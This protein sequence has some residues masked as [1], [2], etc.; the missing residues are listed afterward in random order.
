MTAAAAYI[1][2]LM[3]FQEKRTA[4]RRRVLKGGFVS[5]NGRHSD[6]PCTVRDIS[7][8]GARLKVKDGVNIP[9]RFELLIELDGLEAQCEVVRREINEVGVRFLSA[10]RQGVPM[11]VQILSQSVSKVQPPP[12]LRR[13][14]IT[15]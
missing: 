7:A 9:S 14:P 2:S 6:F 8:P 11:R 10:P 13:K 15:A 3:P 4:P 5:F 1:T 12:S